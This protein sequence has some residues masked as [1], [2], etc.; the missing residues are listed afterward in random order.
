M[1]PELVLKGVNEFYPK[2]NN[3]IYNIYKIDNSKKEN[4]MVNFFIKFME[5]QD[6]KEKN[7]I[8]KLLP[9]FK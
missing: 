9:F 2:L 8:L 3:K 5:N 6:K 4:L 1:N 7:G